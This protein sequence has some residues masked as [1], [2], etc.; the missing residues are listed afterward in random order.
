MMTWIVK[1]LLNKKR[2]LWY[3]GFEM[4]AY[5]K[6]FQIHELIKLKFIFQTLEFFKVEI[7]RMPTSLCFYF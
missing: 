2:H 5:T 6:L 7:M 1:S 3:F 4:S